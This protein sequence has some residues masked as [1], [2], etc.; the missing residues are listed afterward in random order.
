MIKEKRKKRRRFKNVLIGI[1]IFMLIVAISALIVVK[2]FVVKNV[3]IEGNELYDEQLITETVLNDKYSWNSLYVLLK[4]TFIDM[5]EV[6]FIDTMEVSL[7]DPQTLKVKVYEKGMLGYLYISAI[8]EN[9]YFDKDG[10]VVETSARIIENV[11]KIEGIICDE[12]VLYEKLPIDNQTLR[13]LL[14]LTQAL[15]RVHLEPDVIHYGLKQSPILTYGNKEVWL[16]SMKLLTQKVEIMK[17]NL[18][19]LEG[20]AGIMHLENWTEESRP[21]IFEKELEMPDADTGDG[22]GENQDT[23]SESAN[24]S[25]R[26]QDN[27]SNNGN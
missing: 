26:P 19:K 7:A 5:E 18:P 20:M 22:A 12:V 6:P 27:D 17:I 11:P 16:G 24:A 13:E 4:Y 21:F 9:A 23:E 10:F 8:G 2:V 15:K 25:E 14:T 1:L 3:K